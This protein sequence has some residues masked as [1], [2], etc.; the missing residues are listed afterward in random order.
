MWINI[1][2]NLPNGIIRLNPLLF[3]IYIYNKNIYEKRLT[4]TLIIDTKRENKN[5]CTS[6]NPKKKNDNV[7]PRSQVLIFINIFGL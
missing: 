5:S 4:R 7:P 3:N 6:Y 1:F 2:T